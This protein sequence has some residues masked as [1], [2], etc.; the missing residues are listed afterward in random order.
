M[1]KP[2]FTAWFELHYQQ[3]GES[4]SAAINRFAAEHTIN[5]PTIFYA[6]L[7]ARVAVETAQKIEQATGGTVPLAVLVTGKPRAEVRA[8]S[9]HG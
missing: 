1:E 4:R 2:A 7:G 6:L 3:P 9:A 5:V 8:R